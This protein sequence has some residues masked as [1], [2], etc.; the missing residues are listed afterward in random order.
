MKRTRITFAEL[1]DFAWNSAVD[2]FLCRPRWKNPAKYA[3]PTAFQIN[4]GGET[5]TVEDGISVALA[6]PATVRRKRAIAIVET[7]L[8]FI[9]FAI[10]SGQL[11]PD[12]NESHYL[13]KAKHFWDANWCPN[14]LFLGSS[15]AHWLFYWLFGWLTKFVSLS[16]F[17]WIGR[18]LT[19]LSLAAAWRFTS[20]RVSSF[21]FVGTMSA[22]L[23]LLLN[24]R[25]HLAGEW[26]VGGFEAKGIAY[27]LVIFALG[28]MVQGNWKP[29]WLL[30]GTA[31]A[32]HVLVGGWAFLAAGLSWI[33]TQ[34]ASRSAGKSHRRL[35]LIREQ[36]LPMVAGIVLLAIGAIP[37]LLADQAASPENSRIASLIYVN[38][39]I[40]HHLVFNAF[41]TIHVAR[42]TI[43]ILVW[44]AMFQWQS[45]ENPA[46]ARSLRPLFW[47]ATGSLL[48]SFGGLVLS[49]IAETND[50]YAEPAAG[51]LRFYWFRLSDFAIPATVSLI[52]SRSVGNWF[53][54]ESSTVRKLL[55]S[56]SMIAILA[57]AAILTFE[58]YSDPRPLADRRSL[59]AYE[60]DETRTQETYRNWRKACEWIRQNTPPDAVVI[61]PQQQQTFKW[62]AGRTEVVNWKDIPQDADSII[63]WSLRVEMLLDVQKRH[64]C[65]LMIY[66]DAQ[67]QQIGEKYGAA[68]LLIPQRHVD[69]SPTPTNLPQVYPEGINT[70]STYVVLKL[71]TED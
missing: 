58:K 20:G 65:G 49:G 50:R 10:F 71:R 5:S 9:C 30:L 59:P 61:T 41:P 38:H 16:V 19:W 14:D 40:A 62:Y 26:V 64:E 33:V 22:I 3:F 63:E 42:F 24:D 52:V 35:K 2:R 27:A 21:P 8:I 60:G 56:V 46:A 23:F 53:V 6:N 39:R 17:A 1:L 69:L 34:P 12:V 55:A 51:L 44:F 43:L 68:F 70:R 57:A 7:L 31:A 18:L 45:K 48:I 47:F 54:M 32:F 66:S 37:P 28:F 15:F 25:F 36:M 13:T 11:P 67:L 4:R 29:V